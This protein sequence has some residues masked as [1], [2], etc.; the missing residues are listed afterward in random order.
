MWVEPHG[1]QELKPVLFPQT[2]GSTQQF[3][4]P[5]FSVGFVKIIKKLSD[6]RFENGFLFPW[7]TKEVES[8]W[9]HKYN[10]ICY[11]CVKM[12]V[13]FKKLGSLVCAI[14]Q[15][16][17]FLKRVL[18]LFSLLC[19]LYFNNTP[20][21]SLFLSLLFYPVLPSWNACTLLGGLFWWCL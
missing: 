15:T 12:F 2:W 21:C 6:C 13:L 9:N 1:A 10:A 20:L 4:A 3:G 16:K 18:P 11:I 14:A 19:V 5:K 8:S 17:S 7:K